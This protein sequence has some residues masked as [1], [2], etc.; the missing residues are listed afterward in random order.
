ME[1][2][3]GPFEQIAD[4]VFVAVAEP[5][6]VNIGLVVG[7][8][9]ALVIDTGCCPAQGAAIRRAAEAVA[10]VPVRA[11]MVTHWHWDHFFGLAGFAGMPSYGHATLD[12]WLQ[13]DGL[14]VSAAEVGVPVRDLVGP[15]HPFSLA[16]VIDLGERRVEMV[17]FGRAHT[18]GDVVAIV[19]DANAIFA[20]DL[21]EQSGPP[22]FGPDCHPKDWPSAVDGILG[23][24][25]EHTV[26]VPGHGGTIDRM[27]AFDQRARISGLYGQAEHL[28][29]RGIRLA[30]AYP[31]GEWPFPEEVVRE[32]LPIIYQELAA[33]GIHP[34]RHLPL[35]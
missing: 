35:A 4:G 16:K 7:K 13:S 3:L 30:E 1:T 2:T 24:V 22:A 19:P 28:A 11:V 20:G 26:V 17:H 32:A 14:A 29:R 18:D 6:S 21:L 9:S 10:Q 15:T 33:D 34:G 23:L 27:Y 5:A 25:D 31:A 12:D 8:Q